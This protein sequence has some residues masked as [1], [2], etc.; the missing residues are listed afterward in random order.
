[1]FARVDDVINVSVDAKPFWIDATSGQLN[2]VL[3]R[4]DSKPIRPD[5]NQ[6]EI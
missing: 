1:M 6:F 4:P 3:I 2:F 5:M